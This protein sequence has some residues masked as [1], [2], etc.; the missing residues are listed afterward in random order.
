MNASLVD[1]VRAYS[2]NFFE[3][4][5]NKPALSVLFVLFVSSP[6]VF[7]DVLDELID[8]LLLCVIIINFV[9]LAL[10]FAVLAV[11]GRLD[12]IAPTRHWWFEVSSTLTITRAC[13]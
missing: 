9:G 10:H 11:D 1:L 12:P 8:I 13:F 5:Y 3:K 2:N 4:P 6:A 7:K